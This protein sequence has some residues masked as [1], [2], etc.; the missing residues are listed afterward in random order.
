MLSACFAR[1]PT[2]FRLSLGTPSNALGEVRKK[3]GL[4]RRPG[5]PMAP[6][7]SGLLLITPILGRVVWRHAYGWLRQPHACMC[8][9]QGVKT[10][11]CGHR[12]SHP[13]RSPSC[14]ANTVHA[15]QNLLHTLCNSYRTS[16][17]PPS[18][19]SSLY[20]SYR[21]PAIA[22]ESP[23]GWSGKLCVPSVQASVKLRHSRRQASA[24]YAAP[25]RRLASS[26]AANSAHLSAGQSAHT[27][28]FIWFQVPCAASPGRRLHE[29]VHPAA[30]KHAFLAHT[31]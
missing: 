4:T 27:H 9:L 7:H 18:A 25:E 31:P 13:L 1:A 8:C 20:L 14:P 3:R 23:R 24:S 6:C 2:P 22:T 11:L 5:V 29:P 30:G 10:Q 21:R 16:G 15:S 28:A 12:F 17:R 19:A 26:R